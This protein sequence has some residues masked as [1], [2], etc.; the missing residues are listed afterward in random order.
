MV[1]TAPGRGEVAHAGGSCD[2]GGIVP[3]SRQHAT[4]TL[5]IGIADHREQGFLLR[6]SVN[7]EACVEYL[8]S[9]VLGIGLREHH[10]LDVGWIAAHRG[11]ACL[12]IVD[13]SIRK[14]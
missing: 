3:I 11:E 14:S 1:D 7:A 6:V 12:Q 13:L 8:V 5:R 4:R 2:H 9:A 10:E